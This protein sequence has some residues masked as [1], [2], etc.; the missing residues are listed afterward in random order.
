ML[1]RGVDTPDMDVTW[2]SSLSWYFL[3]LF[4]LNSIYTL[5]LGGDNAADQTKDMQGVRIQG[6]LGLGSVLT[7]VQMN[8]GMPGAG[9]PAMPGQPQ[10][11]FQK[12]YDAEAENLELSTPESHRWACDEVEER[13]LKL[14]KLR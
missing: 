12:L 1:Q 7:A 8:A 14:Y 4:G 6:L 5:I 11:N 2:V 3:N 10:Q 13:L 9:A